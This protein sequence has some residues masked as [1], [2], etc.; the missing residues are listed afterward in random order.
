QREFKQH[1]RSGF[2]KNDDKVKGHD[3]ESSSCM[4]GGPK[5]HSSDKKFSLKCYNCH[6]K[7]LLERDFRSNKVVESNNITSKSENEWDFEASFD[8]DEEEFSF[9]II[10]SDKNIDYKNDWI[11]DSRCSNHMTG[12]I[13]NLKD[14][15]NYTGSRVVVTTN[16]SK[17]P[18]AHVGNTIVSPLCNNT[19][20]SLKDVF[21]VLGMKKNFMLVAQLTSSGQYV[22][23]GLQDVKIYRNFKVH[24]CQYGKAHQFSYEESKFKAK[25]SLE[26]IHTDVFGPVKQPSIGENLYIMAFIDDFS[27]KKSAEAEIGKDV[28]CLHTDNRGEYTYDKFSNF[29]Q[30]TKDMMAKEKDGDVST[31]QPGNATH[32]EMLYLMKPRLGGPLV[33]MYYPDYRVF[34]EALEDSHIQLTLKDDEALDSDQNIE[35][36]NSEWR[37]AME[38]KVDALERNQ[39]WELS[40]K[41][42]DVKP[43]SCKW[44]YKIKRHTDGSIKRYKTRLVAWGFSQQYGLDYDEMF[45]LV[46]KL[47][48]VRNAFLHKELDREIYMNQQIGFQSQDH[49][50]YVGYSVIS[51]NFSLFIKVV[52]GKL[53]VVL[54]YVNDLIIT[55]DYEEEVLQTKKNLSIHFQMK[56]IRNL[57]HFLGLEVDHSDDGMVL[58]QQ[59]YSRDLLK[60]FRND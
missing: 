22:L 60:K 33:M 6:K 40:P 29:L 18:I 5:S 51:I 32:L 53:D 41:P 44:V 59:K 13:I 45:I 14:V 28:R 27:F 47:T 56:E 4:R 11:V 10:T 49:P 8:V 24:G 37:K 39:N 52:E 21:H 36:I 3:D 58:H 38:E 26:L 46:A 2:K 16:N 35:G 50:E 55:R 57:K 48:M 1:F 15:S 19:D 54:V 34:K 25:E 23:F 42:K 17:L 20:V 31:Q 12:D 9:T 7:G 30:E 43:I